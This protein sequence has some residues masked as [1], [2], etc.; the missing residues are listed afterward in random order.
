MS[1]DNFV[2]IKTHEELQEFIGQVF[3]SFAI[4][5]LA[6]GL[7]NDFEEYTPAHGQE[8]LDGIKDEIADIPDGMTPEEAREYLFKRFTWSLN[9]EERQ[10]IRDS[11]HGVEGFLMLFDKAP[12]IVAQ[13]DFIQ[14][15]EDG[16]S[17]N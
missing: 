1:D 2:E 3:E 11:E 17:E 10:M 5:R 6:L 4:L 8:V 7:S 15:P 9:E 12:T 16:T 14:T 13:M